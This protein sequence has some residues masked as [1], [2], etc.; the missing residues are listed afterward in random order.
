MDYKQRAENYINDYVEGKGKQV[1]YVWN[2][3]SSTNKA[4]IY[5]CSIGD[6]EVVEFL[7]KDSRVDP[8]DASNQGIPFFLSF[9]NWR[10]FV[11]ASKNGHKEI[12]S[13][14]LKDERIDP[15]SDNNKGYIFFSMIN[16]QWS[17]SIGIL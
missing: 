8:T 14:L 6:L 5:A 11:Q 2:T 10:A 15:S 1:G 13:L 4:F 9:Y 17:I 12:V 3:S 16:K 7:L